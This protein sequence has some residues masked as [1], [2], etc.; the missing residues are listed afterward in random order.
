M[1][2]QAQQQ[3]KWGKGWG[4]ELSGFYRTKGL[5]GVIFIDPIAQVNVGLSKQVM[6]NKGSIRLNVHDIFAGSVF[7]GYS[8]YSNVDIQFKDVNDSRGISLSFTY[9]F[10][11]GKL[12]G[13]R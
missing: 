3:F 11:K 4:A 12:K 10:N 8:R 13:N 5:E 9:K 7:T 6:N 1:M 2:V